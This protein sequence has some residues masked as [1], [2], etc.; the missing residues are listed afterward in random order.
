MSHPACSMAGFDSPSFARTTF[1]SG[2]V[3]TWILAGLY[4]YITSQLHTY[5]T[6]YQSDALWKKSMVSVLWV[7]ITLHAIITFHS[8]YNYF[9]TDLFSPHALKNNIWSLNTSILLHVLVVAI[10]L[11]YFVSRIYGLCSKR[12][13]WWITGI[14]LIS[15]LVHIAF[16][17]VTVYYLFRTRFLSDV[18]KLN[19]FAL[20]PMMISQVVTDLLI[21]IALCLLLKEKK[22]SF[23]RTRSILR[24]M[25]IY[26]ISRCILTS[27]VVAVELLVVLIDKDALW[28]VGCE[29]LLP[30]LYVM[31]LITSLNVRN[32]ISKPDSEQES[33]MNSFHLSGIRYE[34]ETIITTDSI[35]G[36]SQTKVVGLKK[37]SDLESVSASIQE[38]SVQSKQ[39][40]VMP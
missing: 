23:K 21:V 5:F 16:G 10:V 25:M 19:N 32:T 34:T 26:A 15:V 14:I 3:G 40:V 28:Y 37:K 22:T 1:G 9:I 12:W 39:F 18:H 38:P 31:S 17:I 35:N 2:L 11:A 33:N 36:S 13:R 30:D 8:Q 7:L 29:F 24:T 4:G 6:T 27:A 20:I